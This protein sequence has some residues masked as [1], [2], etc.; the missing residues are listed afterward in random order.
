[1]PKGMPW[2]R[3]YSEIIDDEKIRLL[4]FEDRW[5]YIAILCMKGDG[6][7]DSGDNPELMMRKVSVK[8]GLAIR[9]VDEV[10]RR[11]SDVG[12]V[13]QNTLQ[14]LK[15]NE[16][17]FKSDSSKER[18]KAFRE[19]QKKQQLKIT[20]QACNVTVTCQDTDT[21]TD[22]VLKASG[23][24]IC[25]PRKKKPNLTEQECQLIANH[26]NEKLG[27]RLPR[28][29]IM[30]DKRIRL[31]NA[32]YKEA[33][34]TIGANGKVRYTDKESGIAWFGRL[35]HKATLRDSFYFGDNDRGW[36][37]TFDWMLSPKAFTELIEFVPPRK[38]Q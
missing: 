22:K 34:D 15:W 14:P 3:L 35:F 18:V 28:A 1:M 31:I 37:A 12:L 8:M 32:R 38:E 24:A 21:D 20:K 10:A 4:A 13:D 36:T 7:L 9:E 19:K 26:Y 30:S 6:L 29:E 5:H 2:L 17:Q 16:R 11:L 25:S 27:D 23:D 33:L